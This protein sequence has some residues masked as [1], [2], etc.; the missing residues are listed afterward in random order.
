M[1]K[2]STPQRLGG[3]DIGI[4]NQLIE[5]AGEGG[6]I[7][8][9]YQQVL[10]L[11]A[12]VENMP[13]ANE[14][15]FSTIFKD[16]EALTAFNLALR[17]VLNGL[18]PAWRQANE[19]F[20][21]AIRQGYKQKSFP[22]VLKNLLN[23]KDQLATLHTMTQT[24]S[25]IEK[26]A[27]EL[28]KQI[29]AGTKKCKTQVE[30]MK[31]DDKRL[32][33]SSAKAAQDRISKEDE[34]K[35]SRLR[36]MVAGET[37]KA[38]DG[39][40]SSFESKFKPILTIDEESSKEPEVEESEN[41]ISFKSL[42]NLILNLSADAKEKATSVIKT[43]KKIRDETTEFLKQV[44]DSLE[45]TT[46]DEQNSEEIKQIL[47]EIEKVRSNLKEGISRISDE[48]SNSQKDEKEIA[49]EIQI[50]I[51]ELNE[52]V[53]TQL[54]KLKD[55]YTQTMSKISDTSIEI[56]TNPLKKVGPDGSPQTELVSFGS[57]SGKGQK[58]EKSR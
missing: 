50:K 40:K 23:L 48:I 18:P 15:Q 45:N 20:M 2:I 41:K 16:I 53:S 21:N 55:Q 12:R 36:M 43:A 34:R 13:G 37:K 26:L 17:Q 19:G 25:S 1:S 49:N 52:K 8:Q 11:I 14:K 9:V 42:K 56:V 30:E 44:K 27:Q 4:I 35:K 54:S 31:R 5:H 46:V 47:E 3:I 28:S 22:T 7:D 6:K 38:E 10:N 29:E 39:K 32:I 51:E 57:I 33:F 58:K 24:A